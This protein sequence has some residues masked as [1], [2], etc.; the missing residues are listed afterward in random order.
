ML[1]ASKLQKLMILLGVAG[2]FAVTGEFA[3]LE[4][5]CADLRSAEYRSLEQIE[6]DRV[7][8]L[9]EALTRTGLSLTPE[10]QRRLDLRGELPGVLKL[11]R[12]VKHPNGTV[13][14]PA[15]WLPAIPAGHPWGKTLTPA[16]D[17]FYSFVE[18]RIFKA[19]LY[20]PSN[21]EHVAAAK[22]YLA[23]ASSPNPEFVGWTYAQKTE[24]MKK[25]A[26]P[27]DAGRD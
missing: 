10:Q 7:L 17:A 5:V 12:P 19:K 15:G 9:K 8:T 14:M 25:G 6:R 2:L 18:E 13:E 16:D 3:C 23:K 21:P 1:N 24:C 27:A 11:D 22:A 20:D 4:D 26:P